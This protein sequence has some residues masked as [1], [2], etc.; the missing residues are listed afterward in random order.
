MIPIDICVKGCII[1]A[2]K[3]WKDNIG[4]T[5]KSRPIQI[6]NAAS[7]KNKYL[8]YHNLKMNAAKMAEELPLKKMFWKPSAIFTSCKYFYWLIYFFLQLL[9]A[10][11]TDTALK[12]MKRKPQLV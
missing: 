4:I 10:L 8:T 11:L 6:Y 9:P 5:V 3:E 2:W 1:A 7:L 12:L